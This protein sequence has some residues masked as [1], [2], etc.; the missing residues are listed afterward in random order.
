MVDYVELKPGI[1]PGPGHLADVVTSIG[2][3]H[4]RVVVAHPF[5]DQKL[6]ELVAEKGGAKLVILPLDV[7]GAPGASD[8]SSFYDVVIRSLTRAAT[9]RP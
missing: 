6:A 7:G 1:Q 3:E 9:E 5:N 2:R 4:A 8:L